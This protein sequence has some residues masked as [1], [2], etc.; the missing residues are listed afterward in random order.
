MLKPTQR[1]CFECQSGRMHIVQGDYIVSSKLFQNKCV[2]VQNI[3]YL[4]CLKCGTGATI[5]AT[6]S[7]DAINK[8][9]RKEYNDFIGKFPIKDFMTFEEVADELNFTR[10][11][12]KGI[13]YLIYCTEFESEIVFLRKSV[14]QFKKT[15]DGRFKWKSKLE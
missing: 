2:L 5:Y 7:S 14:A 11:D 1:W 12:V 8:A 6:P 13:S 9:H 4:L 3:E 10:Q 15:G